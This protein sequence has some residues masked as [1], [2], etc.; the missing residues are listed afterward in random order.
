MQWYNTKEELPPTDEDIFVLV[1]NGES[2]WAYYVM[3]YDGN[4]YFW[5]TINNMA[6]HKSH[7]LAWAYTDDIEVVLDELGLFKE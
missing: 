3:Y 5:F 6:V 4:D 7:C 2:D 1:A